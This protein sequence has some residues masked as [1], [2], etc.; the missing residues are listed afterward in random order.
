MTTTTKIISES[1]RR[2]RQRIQSYQDLRDEKGIRFSRQWI[3][4]LIKDG[5]FPRSVKLGEASVG[6]VEAEVDDWIENLIQQRD[7]AAA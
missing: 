7:G 6:F 5:K 1:D 4:K 3:V 2:H